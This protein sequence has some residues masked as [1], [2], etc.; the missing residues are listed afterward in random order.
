[1]PMLSAP[2]VNPFGA[3][4]MMPMMVPA[5][6]APVMPPG[7]GPVHSSSGA[8]AAA[9]STVSAPATVVPDKASAFEEFR[10]QF[11]KAQV[12]HTLSCKLCLC[13]SDS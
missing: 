5:M 3:S 2:V 10:Q 12:G 7:V 11:G 1:M 8:A 13:D 6:T 4:M 9:A